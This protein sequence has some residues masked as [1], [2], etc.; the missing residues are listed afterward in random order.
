M[1]PARSRRTTLLAFLALT[2]LLAAACG[3]GGAGG[4]A[5]LARAIDESDPDKPITEPFV[6]DFLLGEEI[7]V[8]LEVPEPLDADF[9]L[10]RLD[11]RVGTQYLPRDQF[12]LTVIPPWNVAVI[13]ITV[14]EVGHWSVAFIVNSRKITDVEFDVERR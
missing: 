14:P 6:G 7:L 9:I 13:P 11:R 10:V 8:R 1:I 3:L 5:E 12:A 4:S 2:P